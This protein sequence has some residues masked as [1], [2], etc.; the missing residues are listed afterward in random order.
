LLLDKEKA[1]QGLLYFI[2]R[3]NKLAKQ[4]EYYN[5]FFSNCT[6]NLYDALKQ[7]SNKKV[8]FS[9]EIIFS[10]FVPRYLRKYGYIKC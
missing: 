3:T 2:Q 4:P 9:W 10:A 5:V 8:K 7:F 6:T 1:K